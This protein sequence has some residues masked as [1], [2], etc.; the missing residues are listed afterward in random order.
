MNKKPF[1]SKH[2]FL[3]YPQCVGYTKLIVLQ[4]LVNIVRGQ[5]KQIEKYIVAEELH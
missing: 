2:L 3:T 4:Q 1:E 5:G